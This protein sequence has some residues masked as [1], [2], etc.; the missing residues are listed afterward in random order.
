MVVA[1]APRVVVVVLVPKT[2]IIRLGLLEFLW[3]SS[4]KR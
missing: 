4:R 2:S 3:R 1:V